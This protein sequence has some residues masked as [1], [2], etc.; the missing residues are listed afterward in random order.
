MGSPGMIR[1]ISQSL[2][3][4]SVIK[5]ASDIVVYID[6][7]D[8]LIN[9]YLQEGG[10][11]VPFNNYVNAWS[12]S[13]DIDTMVP[14]GSLTLVVPVQSMS[15]FELPGGNK[16]LKS[17]TE[18]RVFAK[19][20]YFSAQGNTVYHQI[21]KG[22]ITAVNSTNDG[23][24]MTYTLP[25]RGALGILERMQVDQ[26]P[27]TQSSSPL[28]VTPFVSNQSG[29]DPYGM[30][31]WIFVYSSMI[32]G[33]TI[34]SLLQARI[35]EN[36]NPYRQAVEERFVAKW[37]AL[38]YDLARD[39]HIF[40]A[41]NVKD[42]IS[43]IAENIKPPDASQAPMDKDA[44]GI[45]TNRVGK[46][47]ESTVAANQDD[48]YVQLRNYHPDF[49]LGSIQL[50]N[51]QTTTR[52]ERLRYIVS[53]IGFE[54]YQDVDGGIVIKPPLYNLDVVNLFNDGSEDNADLIGLSTALGVPAPAA[55]PADPPPDQSVNWIT[56][57]KNPYVVYADEIRPGE[58]ET[59][60]EAGVRLTRIQAYGNWDPGFQVGGP[61]QLRTFVEDVDIAKLAQY[62][63]R[64]EP[65]KEA[66]MFRDGDNKGVYAYAASELAKMNKGYRTFTCQIPM[67]PELK[68]GFPIYFPHKDMYGY[69]KTITMQWTR[70]GDALTSITCDALRFRPLFP[71][72]QQAPIPNQP[73]KQQLTRFLTQS[74]NLVL[75]WTQAAMNNTASA[76]SAGSA[77]SQAVHGVSTPSPAQGTSTGQGNANPS[78]KAMTLPFPQQL[79]IKQQQQM[80]DSLKAG[81]LLYTPNND[82][83]THNWRIQPDQTNAF[84]GPRSLDPSYYETLRT[85][86]PYTDHKGYEL[87]GP[88]P[89]GRWKSLK[90]S[91][92]TFTVLNPVFNSSQ[93]PP[94][95]LQPVNPAADNLTNANAFMFTGD[96]VAGSSENATTLL[97]NLNSQRVAIN[98][99]K[100]FELSYTNDPTNTPGPEANLGASAPAQ[101]SANTAQAQNAAAAATFLTGLPNNENVFSA[102]L[103]SIPSD[104]DVNLG[105]F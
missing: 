50:F 43:S 24:H 18:I 57:T 80:L 39:V 95:G 10:L 23:I 72:D 9:P 73:G 12:S 90:D 62:G 71:E 53:L 34:E 99:F 105:L 92:S 88:F 37:Q 70:G 8:Y 36:S 54:A 65:P 87:I 93:T 85:I 83:A 27:G 103:N 61:I 29:L 74:P 19:G 38:L 81:T 6:G 33:F 31:A 94:G 14:S 79:V 25:C 21:F 100:V 63:L 1:D 49:K 45:W 77:I 86:R 26:S 52:L 20:Y 84:D 30:I 60:D 76:G 56:D 104:D 64:T 17:M 5:Q 2:G 101:P 102:I 96:A 48:F 7:A 75:Q 15:L 3:N 22:Y 59:E 51:A 89:W 68:L 55:V 98:N 82:T 35:T 91:L 40:G 58:S 41:P 67:R 78:G 46:L 28:T 42:I 11:R 97:N 44:L 4:R 13:Y 16:V 69:V 66:P 32:D 47:S